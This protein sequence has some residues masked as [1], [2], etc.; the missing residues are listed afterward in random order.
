VAVR[1]DVDERAKNAVLIR[2]ASAGATVE[3][4]ESALFDAKVERDR[5]I[6]RASELGISRREVASAVGL[7]PAGI[8]QILH[9]S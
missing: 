8:Q 1:E 6:K 3:K 5:E 9:R 7:T 2:L 4:S